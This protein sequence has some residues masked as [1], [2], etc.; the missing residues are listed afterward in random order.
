[1]TDRDRRPGWLQ[2]FLARVQQDPPHNSRWGELDALRDAAVLVLLID[3]PDGPLLLL[4]KRAPKLTNYPGRLVFPGG[5]AEPGDAGPVGTALRETSEEIGI[6]AD[7]VHIIGLLPPIALT[8]SGFMVTA[9]VGW[10]TRLELAGTGNS[11]EVSAI[12]QV[13]LHEFCDASSRVQRVEAGHAAFGS[14]LRVDGTAVGTMT[15]AVIDLLS[16]SVG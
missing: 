6:A 14:A 10:C 1:M 8:A 2:P 15:A 13:P 7:T 16:G 5:A 11:D 3:S 12:V 9:V 4:T